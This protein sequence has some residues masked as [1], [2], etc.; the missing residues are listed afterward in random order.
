MSSFKVAPFTF[1]QPE[2]EIKKACGSL[3]SENPGQVNEIA[4]A[5]QGL[6]RCGLI[7]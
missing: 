5:A 7:C 6:K 3:Y 1:L 4:F 2:H